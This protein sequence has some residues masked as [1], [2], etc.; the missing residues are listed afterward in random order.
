MALRS[1]DDPGYW[2]ER[3]EEIRAVGKQ[4]VDAN[5]R[6]SMLKIADSYDQLAKNADRRVRLLAESH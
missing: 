6:A 5:S 4:M 3:A 1:I 2:H